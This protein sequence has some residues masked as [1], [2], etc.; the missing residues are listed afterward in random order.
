MFV[1]IFFTNLFRNFCLSKKNWPIYVYWSAC[2]LNANLVRFS[3]NLNSLDD[4]RRR[5]K[6]QNSIKSAL[7]EPCCS[8]RTDRQTKM[9]KLKVVFRNFSN[10]PKGKQERKLHTHTQ[11]HTHL[12]PDFILQVFFSWLYKPLWARTSFYR[13]FAITLSRAPLDE[14]SDRIR[15]LCLTTHNPHKR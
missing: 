8:M 10:A 13:G 11:T 12:L 9:T 3:W 6:Y 2:T 7:W 1:L 5:I 14:W 4:F 15:D